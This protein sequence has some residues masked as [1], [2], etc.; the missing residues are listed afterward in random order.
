MGELAT[1]TRAVVVV[2]VWR[3]LLKHLLSVRETVGF[4]SG[5]TGGKLL[6]I[7][8]PQS[9]GASMSCC[10]VVSAKSER[11]ALLWGLSAGS[12]PDTSNMSRYSRCNVLVV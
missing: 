3:N 12:G 9:K 7:S 10:R 1:W 8:L 4:S 2:A 11:V 5:A 6:S